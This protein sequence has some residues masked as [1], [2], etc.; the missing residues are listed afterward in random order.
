MVAVVVTVTV[1][2]VV[3][4]VLAHP[5]TMRQAPTAGSARAGWRS[6]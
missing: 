4:A 5:A 2:V 1:T 3:T 6:G